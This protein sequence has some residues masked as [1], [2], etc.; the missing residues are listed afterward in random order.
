MEYL[1]FASLRI[2]IVSSFKCPRGSFR[3]GRGQVNDEP[4]PHVLL[5]VR[6]NSSGDEKGSPL[7]GSLPA[8]G[9]RG[10]TWPQRSIL[11]RIYFCLAKTGRRRILSHT[12]SRFSIRS[13]PGTLT[14][15]NSTAQGG[16]RSG[17]DAVLGTLSGDLLFMVGAE[18]GLAAI[19][20]AHPGILQMGF[21]RIS[22]DFG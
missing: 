22:V 5:G 15:L 12:P 1:V 2:C 6:Q 10:Q 18:L 8:S 20:T 21:D 3:I 16:V 19:L 4:I 17:I 7:S 13:W 9:E 14:I 11:G